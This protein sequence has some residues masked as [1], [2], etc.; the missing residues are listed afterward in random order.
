V[1]SATTWI[2]GSDNSA[3]HSRQLAVGTRPLGVAMYEH[4]ETTDGRQ[5][6]FIRTLVR[7]RPIT[8]FLIIAIGLSWP[9]M[10]ALLAGGQDISPGI[11]LMVIL[12]LGGA[13]LV[14]ALSEGRAGVRRLFTG[15]IRWRMGVARF[16]VM[17]TAMPLLTLLVG[18]LTATLHAPA[19]GWLT[20][21]GSYLFQTFI[22]G[23][24][25]VNLWEE[26]AWG[27]FMQSRLM[28]RRGLLIG[29][30]LTAIP[31]FIIHIP[32]AFAEHGW[33]DTTWA[34]AALDIGLIALVAPFFRY[35]LGTQLVDSGGSIL[36][37]GLLH[38]SFN[39]A[40]QMSA[41]PGGWQYVPAMIM[42]TMAVIAYRRWRGRSF[43]HGFAPTL[44]A[45]PTSVVTYP[46]PTSVNPQ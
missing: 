44:V 33:K 39:A 27:G 5:P 34:Q 43:T 11:L 15:T 6:N 1:R 2:V 12:L 3:R 24:L 9:V 21:I 8:I 41:V 42:L 20:L 45:D 13:T 19:G 22:V 28:A 38:A 23:L 37:I 14:T 16:L 35:L 30:L 25:I 31:F 36:A 18:A 29:S 46:G 4:T 32:L 26:T 40:G 10:I 7:R 17:V